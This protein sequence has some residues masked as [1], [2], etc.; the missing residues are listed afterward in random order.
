METKKSILKRV[1]VAGGAVLVVLGSLA[2][3]PVPIVPEA[4][5][6]EVTGTVA[7]V[8]EGGPFDVMFELPGVDQ[9]YYVNRG[10]ERGLDLTNL[11][12]T[13]VGNTVTLKYPDYWTPLDPIG[14]IRHVSKVEFGDAV[15]FDET[16]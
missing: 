7:R 13:V 3:R 8:F 11:R 10:L 6:L 4:D 14:S 12:E 15:L 1:C 2:I 16:R 5:C 9:R